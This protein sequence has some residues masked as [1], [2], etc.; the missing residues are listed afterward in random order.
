M[1]LLYILAYLDID[2]LIYLINNNKVL[3]VERNFIEDHLH[4]IYSLFI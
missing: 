1:S 4:Y 2:I 3:L